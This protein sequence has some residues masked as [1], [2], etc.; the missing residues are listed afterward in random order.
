MLAFIIGFLIIILLI[1]YRPGKFSEGGIALLGLFALLLLSLIKWAEI[2]WALLGNE[3]LHPFQIVIILVTLAVLSTTLDDY[4]FFKFAAYKAILWSKN[5]G[6][7][8]FRNFFLLTF[9]LTSFTSNDIDVLTVTPIILWFALA[10]KKINPWPYLFYVFVVANTSSMEWLIGNLTNIIVGTVFNLGFIEFLLIMIIPTLVTL[11][12]QYLFLRLIFNN[13]LPNKILDKQELEKVN[14]VV[15]QPLANKRKNIFVLTVLILVILG[16]ALSDFLPIELWMVTTMGALIV[17]LSNE[18]NLKERLKVIPWNV[19]VFVLVFIILTTKLQSLG[20]IDWLALNFKGILTDFWGGIYFASF[21]SAIISGIINNIPAA[22]SLSSVFHTLTSGFDIIHTKAVAYGLV[23]GTNLG[24]L[25]TPV[26]ALATILWLTLIRKRG[27][28]FSVGK[29]I[30][31]G[32][33]VG[34]LSIL[35]ASSVLG[36]ELILLN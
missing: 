20:V 36:I 16:A 35:V 27:F 33:L 13:Q 21:F 4:G 34:S 19:E 32:L 17:L 30:G 7:I 8:L 15:S 10:T 31:Y 11:I 5:N 23:I 3:L 1:I 29:F 24:S 14:R 28:S 26:G 9:I 25:L 12:F 18:F 22:I 2:P 6:K